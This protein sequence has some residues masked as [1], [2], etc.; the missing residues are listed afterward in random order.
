MNE[1]QECNHLKK[2][3]VSV[4]MKT[5]EVKPLGGSMKMMPARK[6]TCQE[7]ATVHEASHAHNAQ[8]LYYQYRFYDQNGRWPTWKDAIAH[9]DENMQQHW[10]KELT[11]MGVDIEAGHLTPRRK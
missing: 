10:I 3:N 9:C 6:G 2:N 1:P 5:G 11:K 7:C 4:D 8:S